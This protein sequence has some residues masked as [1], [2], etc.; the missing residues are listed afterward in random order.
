MSFDSFIN[1]KVDNKRGRYLKIDV[2]RKF[3][4]KSPDLFKLFKLPS[5]EYRAR[6]EEEEKEEEEE[7]EKQAFWVNRKFYGKIVV[8]S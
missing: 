4:E 6:K 7:E 8:R 1:K 2:C 5:S 3:F